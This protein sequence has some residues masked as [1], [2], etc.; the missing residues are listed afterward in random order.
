MADHGARVI[1]TVEVAV[2]TDRPSTGSNSRRAPT[3]SRE[4]PGSRLSR[5]S[6]SADERTAGVFVIKHR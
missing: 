3:G 2:A 6:P 4:A 1:V 5:R